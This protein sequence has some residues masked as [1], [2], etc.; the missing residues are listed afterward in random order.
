[1]RKL[2]PVSL[3]FFD[4]APFR[5]VTTIRLAVP[6][7]RVF[8]T[9]AE[10][11]TWPRW[12]P[13]MSRAAWTSPNTA[14]IGAER[15]VA[16]RAFGTFRERF[17]AWQPGVR[18]A[19]TMIGTTSPLVDAMAEDY[20]LS[21]VGGGTQLEWVLA[22]RPTRLGNAVKPVLRAIIRR[23]GAG[24]GRRLARYLTSN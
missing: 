3:S 21:A 14:A 11:E 8:A 17:I 18:Y 7:E 20:R 23:I 4:D 6:P 10:P 12:F 22:A 13:M 2:D 9:L 5:V 1:V 24:A 19:F 15:E 16:V